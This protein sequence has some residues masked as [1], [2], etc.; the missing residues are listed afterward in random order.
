MECAHDSHHAP[1]SPQQQHS[2]FPAVDGVPTAMSVVIAEKSTHMTATMHPDGMSAVNADEPRSNK[3]LKNLNFWPVSAHTEEVV[4]TKIQLWTLPPASTGLQ[5]KAKQKP[6]WHE[7]R[8][9]DPSCDIVH[10]RISVVKHVTTALERQ[11]N[12]W[13]LVCDV[14][15]QAPDNKSDDGDGWGGSGVACR[16]RN[17]ALKHQSSGPHKEAMEQFRIR[18]QGRDTGAIVKAEFQKEVTPRRAAL[19]KLVRIVKDLIKAARPLQDFQ[20]ERRLHAKNGLHE[21]C[22]LAGELC[23][24]RARYESDSSVRDLVK[25]AACVC[26]ADVDVAIGS[27]TAI[28]LTNDATSAADKN[29]HSQTWFKLPDGREVF[30]GLA[31]L[32]FNQEEC[33]RFAEEGSLPQH[34]IE[35]NA[36]IKM[37]SGFNTTRCV[38]KQLQDHYESFTAG[39]M[40]AGSTDGTGSNTSKTI[41]MQCILTMLARQEGSCNMVWTVCF[42][43]CLSLA[44]KAAYMDTVYLEVFLE[45]MVAVWKEFAFSTVKKAELDD[46]MKDILE[47]K[48]V[49]ILLGSMQRWLSTYPA[50]VNLKKSLRAVIIQFKRATIPSGNQAEHDS[51][52]GRI[53]SFNFNA[54]VSFL[55]DAVRPVHILSIF[56]QTPGLR[57]QDFRSKYAATRE[58]LVR[59]L[60]D[61]PTMETAPN[62]MQFIQVRIGKIDEDTIPKLKPRVDTPQ[63]RSQRFGDLCRHFIEHIAKAFVRRMLDNM[64]DYFD[65]ANFETL[66]RLE[67]LVAPRSMYSMNSERDC[68]L[69]DGKALPPEGTEEFDAWSEDLSALAT[70]IKMTNTL[71]STLKAEHRQWRNALLLLQLSAVKMG[72]TVTNSQALYDAVKQHGTLHSECPSHY[73]MLEVLN[74]VRITSVSPERGFS[75]LKRFLTRLSQGMGAEML[76]NCMQVAMNA[77]GPEEDDARW[78]ERVV[79]QFCADKPRMLDTNTYN[80]T[81]NQPPMKQKGGV[82]TT[83]TMCQPSS[84]HSTIPAEVPL[85]LPDDVQEEVDSA[86]FLKAIVGASSERA[87]R[88]MAANRMVANQ[89]LQDADMSREQLEAKELAKEN[90][91]AALTADEREMEEE[92]ER[93]QTEARNAKSIVASTMNSQTGTFP[94]FMMAPPEDH[95]SRIMAMANNER[96]SARPKSV[97]RINPDEVGRMNRQAVKESAGAVPKAEKAKRKRGMKQSKEGSPKKQRPL[98][99]QKNNAK[100]DINGVSRPSSASSCPPA[101]GEPSA[102]VSQTASREHL[103]VV[104][105]V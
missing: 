72:T 5:Q 82:K 32:K 59:I 100:G 93:E 51:T 67:R 77:P 94:M 30:A 78:C 20:R 95:E 35:P 50:V 3:A 56:I 97:V 6:H 52:L 31:R 70:D 10:F 11:F 26:R 33:I 103:S 7:G 98:Y 22:P 53:Q 76:D 18:A 2:C 89:R 34:L 8:R 13:A 71:V 40:T 4:K 69:V 96:R 88:L 48:R 104:C 65:A 90:R 36:K 74:T 28:G 80:S 86:A 19:A 38:M 14:C 44:I 68:V 43:H 12:S 64:D 29:E 60:E 87:R 83:Q 66:E 15:A 17:R 84:F 102:V 9:C 54:T 25:A 63:N 99:K 45:V 79:E 75:W 41:G 85:P 62:F 105:G 46:I 55:P 42:A 58:P 21:L 16:Q 27:V 91:L 39:K 49:G 81:P 57:V 101:A 73:H 1:S 37:K 23:D 61:G 24:P 92:A 47:M